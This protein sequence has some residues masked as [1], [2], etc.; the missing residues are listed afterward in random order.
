MLY[1]TL[2]CLLDYQT[3]SGIGETGSWRLSSGRKSV[4]DS[5][6]RLVVTEPDELS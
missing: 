2:L 6:G 3:R 1:G 4:A 5:K